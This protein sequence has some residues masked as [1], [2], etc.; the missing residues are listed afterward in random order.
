MKLGKAIW[1]SLNKLFNKDRGKVSEQSSI[2]LLKEDKSPVE[3][4]IDFKEQAQD[5]AF[6]LEPLV[7]KDEIEQSKDIDVIVNSGTP[8]VDYSIIQ[9]IDLVIGFD[10]GTSTSKVV[11]QAPDLQGSPARAV[12]FGNLSLQEFPYLIPT[13]IWINGE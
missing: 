8:A 6:V 3:K 1:T 13:S 2:D 5:S 4:L 7:V 11:I 10:F 9:E 12:N